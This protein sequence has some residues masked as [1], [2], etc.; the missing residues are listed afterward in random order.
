MTSIA[1]DGARFNAMLG[2]LL[3]TRIALC[4]QA[5][6]AMK[7]KTSNFT[8]NQMKFKLVMNINIR[9][10]HILKRSIWLTY[11]YPVNNV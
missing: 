1:S 2:A 7:V 5:L 9:N 10:L 8:Q 11:V 4:F 3:G 6:P